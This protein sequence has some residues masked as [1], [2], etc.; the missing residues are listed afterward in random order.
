MLSHSQKTTGANHK[1]GGFAIWGQND[2]RD[3]T[4]GVQYSVSGYSQMNVVVDTTGE[5]DVQLREG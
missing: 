3:I 2:I 1:V 4:E 5:M